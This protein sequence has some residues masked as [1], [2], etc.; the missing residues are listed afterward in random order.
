[1]SD[2]NSKRCPQCQEEISEKAKKCPKCQADLRAW[3]AKHPVLLAIIIICILGIFSSI[4]ASNDF[5]KADAIVVTA[6]QLANEYKANA[7]QY[8]SKY[9]D[10]KLEVSGVIKTINEKSIRFVGLDFTSTT[11]H[12]STAKKMQDFAQLQ[13]GQKI[14]VIG[15]GDSFMGDPKLTDCVLKK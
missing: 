10:K 1:M 9:K 4:A 13:V 7:A 12:P 8:N 11:C 6:E 15:K 5:E 14:T 3:P 2:S